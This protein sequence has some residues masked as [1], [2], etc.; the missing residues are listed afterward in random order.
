MHW[1]SVPDGAKTLLKVWKMNRKRYINT[2]EIKICHV[3]LYKY[4]R[5]FL[6]CL[7]GLT[8]NIVEWIQL[9]IDYS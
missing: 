7:I 1:L 3:I 6:M 8:W 4:A 5:A 2:R 9:H